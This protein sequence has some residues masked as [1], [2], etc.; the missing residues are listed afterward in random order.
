MR[1]EEETVLKF[2]GVRG[3][4]PTPQNE[5]LRFG[6]NTPCIEVRCGSD[7]LI[8]DAGTGLRML[9]RALTDENAGTPLKLN[10]F[11]THFHWDHIQG[12]PF[13]GPAYDGNNILSYYSGVTDGN[14]REILDGHMAPP[15]FPVQFQE[16]V[17][18]R[19]F[20]SLKH[21]SVKIGAATISAFPLNHPQGAS[22]FRIDTPQG[23]I[24]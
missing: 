7:R 15:Y 23:A 18:C 16:L 10:V 1:S 24:V 13:F 6:G 22:G 17:A 20:Y 3:S 5:N 4:T 8:L 12:M 9:G 2:W 14:L 21:E 19:S 11:L